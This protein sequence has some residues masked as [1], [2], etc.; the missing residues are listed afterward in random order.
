MSRLDLKCIED[1]LPNILDKSTKEDVER[2]EQLIFKHK[3]KNYEHP[4]LSYFEDSPDDYDENVEFYENDFITDPDPRIKEENRVKDPRK[5]VEGDKIII[6]EYIKQTDSLP[7]SFLIR[8]YR[9]ILFCKY[10][11]PNL[12]S[13]KI[14][15]KYPKAHENKYF[16]VNIKTP[17]DFAFG[18]GMSSHVYEGKV[19]V[20]RI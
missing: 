1:L 2:L 19:Y 17:D 6:V 7:L 20:Y 14:E 12:C 15:Y 10:E 4:C 5:L 18:N 3:Y 16:K 9:D 8:P 11:T 13:F